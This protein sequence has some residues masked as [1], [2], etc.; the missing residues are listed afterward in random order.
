M[1]KP[2]NGGAGGSFTSAVTVAQVHENTAQNLIAI[3]EDRL[4]LRLRDYKE[5]IEA[6]RDLIGPAGIVLTLFIT[7]LT[8][9]FNDTFGISKQYIQTAFVL[10]TIA[11]AVWL[12]YAFN[13]SRKAGDASIKT[14]IGE[15]RK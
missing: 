14:L 13:K 15:I 5:K 7:L 2:T 12:S 11:S 6:K 4:E 9:T 10:T 3:T 8:A 1:D